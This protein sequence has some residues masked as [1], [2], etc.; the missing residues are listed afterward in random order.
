MTLTPIQAFESE[1]RQDSHTRTPDRTRLMP[2]VF[3]RHGGPTMADTE[4][5]AARFCTKTLFMVECKVL[6]CMVLRLEAERIG[7]QCK[8]VFVEHCAGRERV[9]P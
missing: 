3:E 6:D 5:C 1:R 9:A 7:G 2:D 8:D 4:V